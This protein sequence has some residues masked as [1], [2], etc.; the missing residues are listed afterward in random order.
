MYQQRMERV[1]KAMAQR[2]LAQFLICDPKSIWYLTGYSVEPYERLFV[3]CLRA[4]GQHTLFLNRLFPVP[5]TDLETVWFSDTDD[6]IQCIADRVDGRAAIGIDKEWPARFLLPLLEKCPGLRPVLAS[7]CVDGC[8]SRKDAAEQTLMRRASAIN[9]AVI[10]KAAAYVK[11]G[12]TE[13]QVADFIE[14]EY[15]A[16]GCSGT[17]FP[18]IVSFGANAAD[19]HHEPDDTVLQPGDC[20]LF[21]MGCV[22]DRYCSDMTRTYFCGA[23]TPEQAAVHDLVRRANE[24]AEALIRPGVPLCALDAAARDL[25]A[26]AGYGEYFNHRLGHFIGQVDHEQGDVSAA[27]TV[28]AEPGMIFSIEP[29]VYLPGRFGVRVE[30]LV[31][32]TESGCEVLNRADKHWRVVG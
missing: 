14:A 19:P 22:K 3:L 12:M 25:I 24:A 30:D 15:R 17:A 27:N 8:R 4:G 31:L 29:G 6:P 9:D 21:D 23:P 5:E 11:A 26:A 18:T 1:L 28:L 16:A 7:D 10:E 32:V 2:G 20:V 13:R